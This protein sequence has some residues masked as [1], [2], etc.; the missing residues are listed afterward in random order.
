MRGW[1]L[2]SITLAWPLIAD[3]AATQEIVEFPTEDRW[4]EVD[5]E[6]V[7]RVGSLAGAEWEQFGDVHTVAFDGAGRLHVFDSQAARIVVVDVGGGLIHEFGQEG[8]GPG[9]FRSAVAMAVLADGRVVVGDTGHRAYSLFDANGGFRRM[10][11]M[12]G[13]LRTAIVGRLFGQPG[14]DALVSQASFGFGGTAISVS[15]NA[16]LPPDTTRPIERIDLAG[17]EIAKTTVAEAWLPP[18]AD[19][20]ST[21]MVFNGV[22]MKLP[23]PLAFTAGLHWGVL[24]DGSVAFSD[25]TTYAVKIAAAGAGVLRVYTRPFPPEPITDRFIRADQERRIRDLDATPDEDLRGTTIGGVSVEGPATV[26][27]RRLRRIEKL[28][29]GSEVP[30]IRDLGTTWDGR[31]WVLRRGEQPTSNGPIDVISPDGGYMGSYPAGSTRIPDAFGPDGLVA[32]TE[33]DELGVET[34]VVKRVR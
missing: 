3:R 33:R 27:R 2:A 14:Q 28:A 16:S 25:S 31:I 4:L 32:F 5:F 7:Y 12:S 24:P 21:G 11:R 17:E 26:R 29:Y 19:S 23:R 9:D 6:D 20:L 34:V 18:L 15:D 30:V 10:V 1:L 22:G 8:E 13:D